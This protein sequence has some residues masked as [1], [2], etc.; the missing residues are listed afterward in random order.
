MRCSRY[1]R[2]CATRARVCESPPSVTPARDLSLS[3]NAA[4]L[5]VS[6]PGAGRLREDFTSS[7]RRREAAGG[8]DVSETGAG[9]NRRGRSKPPS[10]SAGARASLWVY[11][12]ASAS[13]S[14]ESAGRRARRL[15]ASSS[16]GCALDC[17][18]RRVGSERFGGGVPSENGVGGLRST[19]GRGG[20]ATSGA[21]AYPA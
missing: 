1:S 19:A 6:S 7:G 14:L 16:T 12:L 11:S 4:S 3:A 5:A 2:G 21:L 20:D 17:S 8:S 15:R 10:D 9:A 18:G 13:W